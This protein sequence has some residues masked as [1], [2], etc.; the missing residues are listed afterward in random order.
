MIAQN[1]QAVV[2]YAMHPNSSLPH[3]IFL[4]SR[5]SA[6]HG[7]RTACM[8]K[9][10]DAYPLFRVLAHLETVWKLLLQL[11]H[12]PCSRLTPSSLYVQVWGRCEGVKVS[13]RWSSSAST[14][15]LQRGSILPGG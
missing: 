10:V 11:Q 14:S 5:W 15:C 2:L 7:C 3:G 9:W 13:A 12:P 1:Y 8:R 6:H 4:L